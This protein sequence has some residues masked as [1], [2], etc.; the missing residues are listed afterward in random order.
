MR[1]KGSTRPSVTAL[2]LAA[3]L[4]LAFLVYRPGLEGP[5]LFDDFANLPALGSYDGV[6]DLETL[7]LYL[8]G[9]HAGP[10]G[11]PLALL[12]FLLD[13]NAWPSDPAPFKRTNLL[14]HLLNG[15]LLFQV[16]RLLLAAAGWRPEAADRTALLGAGLWLLHPLWVSTTL[17]VVQRMA[18][19]STTFVLAGFWGWLD[20]RRRLARAPRAGCLE[21]AAAVILGTGLA[22][23]SKENGVLLP[24]L[25]LVAESTVL[26]GA[27][28]R[29]PRLWRAV[30]LG[31]PAL[32]VAA[33]LLLLLPS[34]MAAFETR[35]FTL[36]ERL[37]T[38]ARVVGEYL[39]RLFDPLAGGRGLYADDYPLSRS[40]FDPPSTAL[41]VALL[42]AWLAAAWRLRR[43]APLFAFASLF[44]LAGHLLESTVIPLE[45]YFE[46]RN[47]LPA[48]FL[49]LPPAAGL[50]RLADRRPVAR[51]LGPALLLLLA[52]ATL[53]Q[54]RLW[55]DEQ[56]L[57]LDWAL[58]NPE[59]VRAQRTAA[60]RLEK[61]GHP[62]A[63]A[64]LLEAAR[65]RM[66]EEP[67]IA[68][69]LALLHCRLGRDTR[70]EFRGI[71][72]LVRRR[73]MDLRAFGLVEQA[74]LDLHGGICRGLEPAA[75][76]RFLDAVAAGPG[77]RGRAGPMRQLEHFRGLLAL[78]EG[79]GRAAAGHFRAS[80]E[81]FP[82]TEAGLLQVGLLATA[83]WYRP[84]LEH[85]DGLKAGTPR[86]RREM[87]RLRRQ[88]L[89]DLA[90]AGREVGE[91]GG[92]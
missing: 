36:G 67:R 25:L 20:G 58:R 33:Y 29:P 66:P 4:A 56:R 26:R 12:S 51:W 91:T 77:V 52:A 53:Q 38:E 89:E 74:A 14:L 43:R 84:A 13:D 10:T 68:I 73:S 63:A 81:W 80:Q 47:Y 78:R 79:R 41:A 18:I 44:Y 34:H 57:L 59:S 48:L 17:Y 30:L 55:S 21:M 65:V 39:W 7:Q 31:L 54:S 76:F 83:G 8:S 90:A 85:L 35:P 22:V 42:A 27:A 46:H 92:E 16:M 82:D 71:M 62:A 87:A 2:A 3:L 64:R 61:D 69:H 19:L 88:L 6:R 40:L 1:M 23:L 28:P 49:F 45:L 24:L 5:F 60:L 72:E 70:A 15:L 50:W 86:H 37:L 75:A 32:A 11:R 9:A